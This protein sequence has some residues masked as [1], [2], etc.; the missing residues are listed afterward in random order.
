MLDTLIREGYSWA[1]LDSMS[2]EDLMD[3]V[4]AKVRLKELKT[5]KKS[6]TRGRRK[7]EPMTLEDFVNGIPK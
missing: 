7:D 2:E 4:Q 5:G 6:Q 3:L 1:D